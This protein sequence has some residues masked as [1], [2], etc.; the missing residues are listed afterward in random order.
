MKKKAHLKKGNTQTIVYVDKLT[1]EIL[2]TITNTSTYLADTKEE[3]YLMYS[4][5]I[6]ILK[7]S[8]DVKVKLFAAL[9]ERYGKGQEFSMSKSLK[10]IIAQETGCKPRSFDTA[11]SFLVKE[12]I[13]VRISSQLYRVNPRHA[14]QG[15]SSDRNVHLKAIIE[16]G[17]KNC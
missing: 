15:S 8:S 14:F 17:Y 7:R 3:F 1:G 5:M 6:L 11:F 12:N 13:I 10:I 9:L 4:S 2:D 16:L